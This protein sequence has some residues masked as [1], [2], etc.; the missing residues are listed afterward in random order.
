MASPGSRRRSRPRRLVPSTTAPPVRRSTPPRPTILH[1]ARGG[2]RGWRRI[3]AGSRRAGRPKGPEQGAGAAQ[4]GRSGRDPKLA[5]STG[6]VSGT[7]HDLV[8]VA[9]GQAGRR[10]QPSRVGIASD[11][12]PTTVN[13]GIGVPFDKE[14][15]APAARAGRRRCG[16]GRRLSTPPVPAS[17]AQPAG[18]L[19]VPSRGQR[20][21]EGRGSSPVPAVAVSDES[22]RDQGVY[23]TLSRCGCPCSWWPRSRGSPRGSSTTSP[24]ARRSRRAR[25]PPPRSSRSS[26]SPVVPMSGGTSAEPSPNPS[27]HSRGDSPSRP[28]RFPDRGATRTAPRNSPCD[29]WA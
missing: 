11:V 6:S 25:S 9:G 14:H 20:H 27:S 1:R 2:R 8:T 5:L 23:A 7:G 3:T 17:P 29:C 21:A 13:L 4:G 15:R 10:R 22:Q 16:R 19:D 18:A 28:T 26:S 24:W 12:E